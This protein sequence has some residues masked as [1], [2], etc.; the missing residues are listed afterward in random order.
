MAHS[1]G[2]TPERRERQRQLIHQWAPWEKST[3]PRTREGKRRSAQNGLGSQPSTAT[4]LLRIV[5]KVAALEE[6]ARGAKRGNRTRKE[7]LDDIKAFFATMGDD[8]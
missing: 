7:K 6:L 1:N 4:R 5:E 8:F 3:G 2:W